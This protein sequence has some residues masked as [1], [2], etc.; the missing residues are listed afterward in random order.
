MMMTEIEKRLFRNQLVI[1]RSLLST[2]APGFAYNKLDRAIRGTVDLF[3]AERIQTEQR[4]KLLIAMY[5]DG[6]GAG[7]I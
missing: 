4:G 7:G 1:M 3:E 6:P 5:G 2:S